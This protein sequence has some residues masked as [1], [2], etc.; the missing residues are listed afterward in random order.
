M[1][2]KGIPVAGLTFVDDTDDG[3]IPLSEVQFVDDKPDQLATARRAFAGAGRQ[4]SNEP[5]E[6]T[7]WEKIKGVGRYLGQAV[8]EA[9]AAISN[10]A[11]AGRVASRSALDTITAGLS[12]RPRKSREDW[13]EELRMLP[14]GSAQYRAHLME[15]AQRAPTRSQLAQNAE[16]RAAENSRQKL[17]GLTGSI[18]AAPLSP[19]GAAAKMASRA[20]PTAAT[21]AARA[22][23]AA[24]IGA[25]GGFTEG[26]SRGLVAGKGIAGSLEEGVDA[27]LAGAGAGVAA[28]SVAAA[29]RRAFRPAIARRERQVVQ[30]L[31][32]NADPTHS[33]RL[34]G[35]YGEAAKPVVEF[36]D[37][38]PSVT[39]ARGNDVKM[40]DVT[41]DIAEQA[42]VKT[43]PLYQRF[44]QLAGTVGVKEVTDHL[45][46]EIGKLAS[47]FGGS[48]VMERSLEEVK[49]RI[50]RV[51]A[52][53]GSDQMS[54]QDLRGWVTKL[55]KDELQ[56]MGAINE[57]ERYA[58]KDALHDIG[59]RFLKERL[60]TYAQLDPGLAQDVAQL[61][62]LNTDIAMALKVNQA[63]KNGVARGYYAKK[64]G[65]GDAISAAIAGGV[66]GTTASPGA[67]VGAYALAKAVPHVVKGIDRKVTAAAA[68]VA[69]GK[70]GPSPYIGQ[71][72]N[73]TTRAYQ[74]SQSRERE[75]AQRLKGMNRRASP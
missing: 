12:E 74:E 19:G 46:T 42:T 61:R 20:L 16:T 64:G 39:A 32:E 58:I 72:A 49:G 45:D 25:A 65:M 62:A 54:H 26:A 48:D 47:D 70:T 6:P 29:G 73:A 60:Q 71:R 57:T 4:P 28:E 9:P 50:L 2:R 24:K 75:K 67:A 52:K 34:A 8:T 53:R 13:E 22:G 56:T 23:R 5:P 41:D 30:Q 35:K 7:T 63:A 59:D 21:F 40:A 55:L 11:E 69:T 36:V 3:G 68:N 15:Q 66:L 31:T 18:A 17:A 1:D 44:D 38:N 14:P 10:P 51:A 43:K 33:R 27:G 37:R